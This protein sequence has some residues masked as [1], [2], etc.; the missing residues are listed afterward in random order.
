MMDDQTPVDAQLIDP[1]VILRGLALEW[2]RALVLT[3]DVGLAVFANPLRY[4]R[5][6]DDLRMVRS[7]LARAAGKG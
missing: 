3:I 7:I 4:L 6:D 1:D 5:I 2:V